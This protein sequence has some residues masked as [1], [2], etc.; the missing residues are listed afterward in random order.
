MY[1][2]NIVWNQEVWTSFDLPPNRDYSHSVCICLPLGEAVVKFNETLILKL[3]KNYFGERITNLMENT[4]FT[5]II[6]FGIWGKRENRK[7]CRA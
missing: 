4:F 5:Y 1:L 3:N 7:K 6:G 2:L